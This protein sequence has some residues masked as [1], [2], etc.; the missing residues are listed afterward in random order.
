MNGVS[1]LTDCQ[2]QSLTDRKDKLRERY[3]EELDKRSTFNADISSGKYRSF[4]R[5]NRTIEEMIEEIL[6]DDKKD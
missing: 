2:R 4:V 3:I 5:R 6:K 1:K